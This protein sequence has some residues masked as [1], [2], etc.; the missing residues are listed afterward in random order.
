MMFII[1]ISGSMAEKVAASA[2]RYL[3][4]GAEVKGN[5]KLAFVK[6]ELIRTIKS[7]PNDAKFDIITFEKEAKYWRGAQTLADE[8]GKKQAVNFVDNLNANGGTNVY[9]ALQSS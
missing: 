4:D 1:D 9:E 7:L 6:A 3:G 5:T 8:K 2:S